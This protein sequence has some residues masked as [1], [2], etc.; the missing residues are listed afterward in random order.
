ML[1]K[2]GHP[3][4]HDAVQGWRAS[5][6]TGH[7]GRSADRTC[8]LRSPCHLPLPERLAFDPICADPNIEWVEHTAG[9][10]A[11]RGW[12]DPMPTPGEI[13][14][15][16]MPHGSYPASKG[17]G[18]GCPKIAKV[19][20]CADIPP[21]FVYSTELFSCDSMPQDGTTTISAV[22]E[23]YAAW[24]SLA[25]LWPPTKPCKDDQAALDAVLTQVMP[26]LVGANCSVAYAA[27]QKYLPNFDCDNSDTMP[28]MR[29]MCCSVCGN[30]PIPDVPPPPAPPPPSVGCAVC[31]HVYDAAKDGGGLPFEQLPDTWRCPVCGAP[32]AAY[33]QQA[34]GEWAH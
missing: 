33:V 13:D 7:C 18:W 32:K 9:T 23:A 28:T 8:D 34:S 21:K 1:W 15:S 5:Q 22:D 17:L 11:A 27:L 16:T 29:H 24:R 20:R 26:P 31:N 3:E 25:G 19:V 2:V 12:T 10:T 4:L 14:P 30:E 6:S